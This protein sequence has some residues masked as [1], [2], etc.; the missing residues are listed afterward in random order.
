M[1]LNDLAALDYPG[2]V[3][4]DAHRLE[5]RYIRGNGETLVISLPT[6]YIGDGHDI[7]E[8]VLECLIARA[9]GMS[10]EDFDVSQ[11]RASLDAMFTAEEAGEIERGE[12]G[13]F[14]MRDSK[15]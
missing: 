6:R 12:D 13:Q 15:C 7:Q 2:L 4:Y 11:A 14:R 3:H 1:T 9:L 8:A 5:A 10:R